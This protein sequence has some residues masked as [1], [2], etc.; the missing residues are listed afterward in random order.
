M[1]PAS[2]RAARAGG[3]QR[4]LAAKIIDKGADDVLALKGNQVFHPG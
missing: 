1:N 2:W 4:G 3:C